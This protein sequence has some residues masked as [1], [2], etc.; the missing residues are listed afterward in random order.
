MT[1][2][3]STIFNPNKLVRNCSIQQLK[4]SL[5]TLL[6]I[7]GDINTTKNENSKFPLEY[8]NI[9]VCKIR[10]GL[11]DIILNKTKEE[12]NSP[13]MPYSEART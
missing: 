6:K 7:K 12:C 1:L 4:C 11:E 8:I 9:L 5:L 10:P 13:Q 3:C 2:K